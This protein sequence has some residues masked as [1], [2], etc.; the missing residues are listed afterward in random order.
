MLARRT[1]LTAESA[2]FLAT[3]CG[4]AGLGLAL[5]YPLVP[6]LATTLFGISAAMFFARP[7]A[8]LIALPASL[9][10]V[11]FAPWTGWITFEELDLLVLAVAAGG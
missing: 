7:T 9:P 4:L 8:W 3:G 11:A 5:H 1:A 6:W 10:I 2:A